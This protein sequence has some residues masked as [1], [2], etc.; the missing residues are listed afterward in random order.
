ML[1]FLINFSVK[2]CNQY[3]NFYFNIIYF[4]STFNLMKKIQNITLNIEITNGLI[5]E[6]ES[7]GNKF[8][9]LSINF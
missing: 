7:G 3:S 4:D 1:V 9:I 6:N 2:L 8:Q 5:I